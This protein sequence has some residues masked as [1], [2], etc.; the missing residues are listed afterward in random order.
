MSMEAA[1]D[2]AHFGAGLFPILTAGT[3]MLSGLKLGPDIAIR[4]T[5]QAMLFIHDRPE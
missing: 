1:K 3:Q 5:S 2:P 4:K